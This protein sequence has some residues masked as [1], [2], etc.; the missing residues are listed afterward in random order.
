[1]IGTVKWFNEAKGFGFIAA[2]NKEYFIHF[3]EISGSGFK[4]LNENDRVEFTPGHNAKGVC[5]TAVKVI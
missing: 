2:D 5:A 4:T 1:M 3:S